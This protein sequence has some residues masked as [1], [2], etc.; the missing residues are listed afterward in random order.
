MSGERRPVSSSSWTGLPP[1][2]P[3]S[4]YNTFKASYRPPRPP[5]RAATGLAAMLL[6]IGLVLL[7]IGWCAILAYH[8]PIRPSPETGHVLALS[9]GRGARA[10]Y[11]TRWE[12]WIGYGLLLLACVVPPAY[13][14]WQN[15]RGRK[16]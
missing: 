7:Y 4:P 14:G 15:L 12:G 10:I 11:V 13:F 9:S 2:P 16:G 6:F 3:P 1:D 8:S 5:G